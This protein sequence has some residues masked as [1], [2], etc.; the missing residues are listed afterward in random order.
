MKWNVLS[1]KIPKDNSELL[2]ILLSNRGILNTKSFLHPKHP[3]TLSYR[4]VGI[5]ER[6]IK[7]AVKRLKQAKE[8]GEKI[9]V[10]GDYDCDGVCATA[11]LW[12]TLYELGMKAFPFIPH[13]ERHGYGLSDAAVDEIFR[14]GKPDIFISVDNGIVAHAQW[15]RLREEGVFTILTDHHEPDESPSPADVIIHTTKLCGTTVAWMLA[16]ALDKRKAA[17]LLDLCALATIADQVPLLE[18]NRSFAFH[19]LKQLNETVRLGLLLLIE[20]GGLQRGAISTYAVNFGIAPRINAMGRLGDALGALQLLCTKNEKRARQLLIRVQQTNTERQELTQASIELARKFARGWEEERVIM[21]YDVSFHE[22]IIGLIASR[23]T[24]EFYKPSIV[25]SV[26]QKTSKASCR[27]VPGVHITNI[28]RA[29]RTDLLEIGGHPMAAGFRIASSHINVFKDHLIAYSREVILKD[30]LI[31]R[32]DVDCQLPSALLSCSTAGHLQE[33]EPHGVGNREPLF[34]FSSLVVASSKRM[35]KERKHLKLQLSSSSQAKM[36]VEA[37][38]FGMGETPL[39]VVGT[40][41]SCIG[42]LRINDWNGKRQVQ[43]LMK[44]MC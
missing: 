43:I 9:I 10:F 5:D 34:L 44:D 15:Q 25:I 33:L 4:D 18:A 12:E 7:R 28:L 14:T 38:G 1:K 26:G 29:L 11:V 17:T 13:R 3:S 30:V 41:F 20:A 22:G 2:H 27:S 35:G 37:I 21:V 39:P 8:K 24:D 32:I 6:E 42:H 19:G 36:L 40:L 31:Q 16:R 23:L